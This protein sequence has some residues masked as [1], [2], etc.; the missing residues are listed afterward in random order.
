MLRKIGF[1]TGELPRKG[2]LEVVPA[3]LRAKLSLGAHGK[4]E[5]GPV[6]FFLNDD[7]RLEEGPR[8]FRRKHLVISRPSLPKPGDM[9]RMGEAEK[10]AHSPN[11]F[12]WK[13]RRS[14]G[15]IKSTS[16][17]DAFNAGAQSS[18]LESAASRIGGC[19]GCAADTATNFLSG[20]SKFDNS[21][22]RGNDA[23][24]PASSRSSRTWN[25]YGG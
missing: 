2:V 10:I 11:F 1:E 15:Q 14:L 22:C 21:G 24:S 16:T 5:I 3:I 19:S 25:I 23:Y 18:H 9:G 12:S 7:V 20:G 17:P 13:R 6:H 8:F 4:A